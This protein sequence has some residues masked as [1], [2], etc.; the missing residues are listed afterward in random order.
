MHQ[1]L[2]RIFNAV[3]QIEYVAESWTLGNIFSILK[4]GKNNKLDKVSYRGITLLNVMGKVFERI[5]LNRWIPKFKAIGI[6]NDFQFAY[7]KN[8]S[9]VLSSFF[10]QEIINHNVEKGSHAIAKC[11]AAFWTLRKPLT[12]YG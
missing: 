5:L 6:P 2:T 1:A 12:P 8:K 11:T 10:L 4:K 7:R 9:C 3:R